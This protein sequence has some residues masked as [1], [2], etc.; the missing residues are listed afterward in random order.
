V[1]L[2]RAV[3]RS[4]R[5]LHKDAGDKQSHDKMGFLDGWGTVLAQLAAFGE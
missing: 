5:V 2:R 3:A 1:T 4:A